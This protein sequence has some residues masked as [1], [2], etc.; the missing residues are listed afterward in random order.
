[1]PFP[2]S[3]TVPRRSVA[4]D[5]RDV[6]ERPEIRSFIKDLDDKREHG[7]VGYGSRALVGLLL[8]RSLYNHRTWT[9]TVRLVSEHHDLQDVLGCAPSSHAA[10]R[11]C[12]KL[13]RDGSPLAACFDRLLASLRAEFPD[14]GSALAVDATE[15][16]PCL[17]QS[18]GP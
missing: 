2:I 3:S 4:D 14:L 6:L 16:H 10:Y 15:T 8:V 9:A 13:L 1:M 12:K 17:P 11:F 5:I 18:P 7:R